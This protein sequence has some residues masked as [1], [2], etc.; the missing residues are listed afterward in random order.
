MRR[1]A[2]LGGVATVLSLAHCATGEDDP[3]RKKPGGVTD[4]SS[5]GSGGSTGDASAG[6]AG[7]LDAASDDALDAAGDAIDDGSADAIAD[8]TTDAEDAGTDAADASTGA[9]LLLVA[10]SVART[11]LSAPAI[12]AH[13]SGALTVV[14]DQGNELSFATWDPQSA[15]WS[16]FS[17]VGAGGLTIASPALAAASGVHLAYLGTDNHLYSNVF[18]P[19]SG[20]QT[21]FTPVEFGGS[22]SFGPSAPALAVSGSGVT[23]A[24]EGNDGNLYTQS[25]QAGWQASV[26]HQLLVKI[27]AGTSP[28]ATFRPTQNQV[29]VAY[30]EV[31][32]HKLLYI[33][34]SGSTWS[35][36]AAVHVS[37]ASASTPALVGLPSGDVVIAYR[38]LDDKVYASVM[39]G[40]SFGAPVNVHPSLGTTTTPALAPG[41]AGRVAELAWVSGSSV[42][43]AS[44]TSSGWS[45]PTAVSA[46][47]ELA[48]AL[49]THVP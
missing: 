46:A 42:Q 31:G 37:A 35:A 48:V 22:H 29:V 43:H 28:A 32:T 11:T 3:Q 12:A 8:A 10:R 6:S 13:A 44:L 40:S 49:A 23:L 18:S 16:S 21:S 1:L 15:A 27:A 34:G 41:I 45:G 25:F 9:R 38:S 20:W 17:H 5:G 4:A 39:T 33:E 30:V 24:Q 7:A 19:G 36:P 26:A 14:R 47:G 2:W